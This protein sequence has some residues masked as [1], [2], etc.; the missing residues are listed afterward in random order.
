MSQE[1]FTACRLMQKEC[2]RAFAE[3]VQG[4]WF[5]WAAHAE[6]YRTSV[7]FVSLSDSTLFMRNKLPEQEASQYEPLARQ[8]TI[9]NVAFYVR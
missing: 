1:G 7:W 5:D 8:R 6:K 4:T 9:Q 3:I 2:K